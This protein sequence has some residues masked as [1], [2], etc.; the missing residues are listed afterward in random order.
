MK[1]CQVVSSRVNFRR[2]AHTS[3]AVT[4]VSMAARNATTQPRRTAASIRVPEGTDPR[5]RAVMDQDRAELKDW[6]SLDEFFIRGVRA[7]YD[8]D[9][10]AAYATER[11]RALKSRDAVE[12][13][14]Q[15][16]EWLTVEVLPLLEVPTPVVRSVDDAKVAE[17]ELRLLTD[18]RWRD[19]LTIPPVGRHRRPREARYV[20][21]RVLDRA[22]TAARHVW[23][24]ERRMTQLRPK[25]KRPFLDRPLDQCKRSAEMTAEAWAY[26]WYVVDEAYWTLRLLG[27]SDRERELE[28]RQAREALR[29][30]G[31]TEFTDALVALAARLVPICDDVVNEDKPVAEAVT[32]AERLVP[33]D[34]REAVE[35][36]S[37]SSQLVEWRT[38]EAKAATLA[39]AAQA[40]LRDMLAEVADRLVA[41]RTGY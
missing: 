17:R 25:E 40:V 33:D 24:A 27:A 13:A 28:A 26:S 41:Q 38:P 1:F 37:A 16:L 29:E 11:L 39:E 3:G 34:P 19:Q 36:V 12:R 14:V 6:R 32:A 4:V 2:L 30:I 31:V 15:L 18:F 5:T 9:E 20:A 10:L 8:D 22:K 7:V 35:L 21:E 23:H